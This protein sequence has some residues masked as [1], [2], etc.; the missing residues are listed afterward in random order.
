MKLLRKLSSVTASLTIKLIICVVGSVVLIFGVFGYINIQNSRNHL[1]G[2]VL[3]S[4]Q[5][6]GDIVKR[7]TRLSMLKNRRDELYHMI[8]Q[9]GDEPGLKRVRILNKEGQITFSTDEHEI[10]SYVD[11]S[12]EACYGCHTREKPLERLS[13]PD[14]ARIFRIN[15]GERT[16]GLIQPI[17]NEPDCYTAACHVHPESK[18]VLGVLDIN[19]SLAKVDE[20]IAEYERNIVLNLLVIMIAISL[21]SAGFVWLMIYGPVKKLIAGTKRIA[22]GDMDYIIEAKSTDELGM[23]AS[24]FNKMTS[25]LKR[26][27]N[28]ITDWTR[29]LEDR[30]EDKTQELQR[31]NQLILQAEKLASVGRLAAIVA[32][33]LNNPLAGI[34]NYSKLLIRRIDNNKISE[35]GYEKSREILDM[36]MSEALRCG[37]IVKN[38]LQFSRQSD[39]MLSPNDIRSI[40]HESIQLIEHL[41]T[42]RNIHLQLDLADELPA[43]NC[44][45][46]KIKQVLLALMI[47]GCDAITEE[48]IIKVSCSYLPS[49]ESVEIKIQDNGVGMDGDMERRIFEPFFTTKEEGEGVGLGLSVA[50]SIIERHGGSIKTESSRNDGTT[51][52]ILLPRFQSEIREES[53]ETGHTTKEAY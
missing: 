16:L 40:I 45:S 11:M 23:L 42:L 17:E 13:R 27:K 24:S 41:I 25:D 52:T 10:N 53:T 29:T 19:I 1:E 51:F 49:A 14:R 6:I 37:D 36:M 15:N 44:D 21:V 46:Q 28:E 38:L 20:T 4:A 9:I 47:N 31:A 26:A 50:L 3:T 33:E 22:M 43:V 35:D 32:H 7:S 39:L 34:V 8:N 30:V 2:L 18:K 5:G 48:G 12:A